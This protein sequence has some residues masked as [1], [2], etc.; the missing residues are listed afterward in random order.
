VDLTRGVSVT[1]A[2]QAVTAAFASLLPRDEPTCAEPLFRVC[3][4]VSGTL[5]GDSIFLYIFGC[6]EKM[7]RKIERL[8]TRVLTRQR[9][10]CRA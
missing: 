5:S 3:A 1:L 6:N 9:R 7:Y 4:T 2:S 10:S 8:Q